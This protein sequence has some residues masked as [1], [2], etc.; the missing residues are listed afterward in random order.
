MKLAGLN[1]FPPLC[2]CNRSMHLF[3]TSKTDET[4][5]SHAQD[6]PD[7]ARFLSVRKRIEENDAGRQRLL[8]RKLALVRGNNSDSVLN[9]NQAS[10]QPL[11]SLREQCVHFR[12]RLDGDYSQN[13]ALTSVP[14][15]F[16]ARRAAGAIE[17]TRQ[18]PFLR[19]FV[20]P[21]EITRTPC[22]D[23]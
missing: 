14:R 8:Q 19:L 5:P 21:A 4:Y 1:R 12:S 22:H 10:L 23:G 17:G 9:G 18:L 13:V 11:P 2:C 6:G 16:R 3:Q 15:R 20:T 7:C